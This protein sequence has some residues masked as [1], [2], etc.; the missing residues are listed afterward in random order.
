[1]GLERITELIMNMAKLSEMCVINAIESYENGII[2]K[3][4]YLNGQR[5]LKY[6]NW[7]YLI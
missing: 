2:E 3:I 6:F 1:M 7:R 4:K 5:N